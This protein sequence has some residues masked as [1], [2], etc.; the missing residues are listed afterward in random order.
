[1]AIDRL[2]AAEWNANSII[3][4]P[5]A[6]DAEFIRRAY[7]DVTGRIPP[8]SA[9]RDFLADESPDRRRDLID[10]LLGTATY[11][12]HSTNL[13]R[14]AMIPEA[15]AD[16]QI[17]FFLPGFEAWL[18]SRI[19][20]NRNYAQ[21]VEEV[22]TLPFDPS[23][24][25][26]FQQPDAPTPAAFYRAKDAQPENLAAATARIFLGLRLECAQCHDH[27][28]DKWKRDEFW[29]YAAF[30]TSLSGEQVM[31]APNSDD[32]STPA[33]QSSRGALAGA[34]A[35]P[36][37]M[38]P[39]TGRTVPARFLDGSEPNWTVDADSRQMLAKWVTSP[40]NEFFARAA[41]NRIWANHFGIG[42]VDPV[43]DLSERNPPSHPEVLDLLADE[44]A[45]HDFDVKFVIRVVT[46][47]RAYGLTSR[48]THESQQT[49]RMFARMA[50]KGLTP[51]QIFDSIAQATGYQ[52]PFNPEEPLNFNNDQRRQEFLENFANSS[53]APTERQSTIL[54]ALSLMNG[55]F[56]A[57]ATD[58]SESRTLA[59]VAESPFLDAQEKV[60]AL[61]LAALSR[62]PAAD[63]SER[64]TAYASAGS[65]TDDPDA[66]LGD[67]FWALLNSSEFLMN[68]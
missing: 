61:F 4:A 19:A 55:E 44:F 8:A 10:R 63:E 66:A 51:E 30:F 33:A 62:P 21:I 54:Q 52:Q 58:L 32:A 48:Q 53:D 50:V 49:P 47:T 57:A 43:D 17:R 67:V 60:E 39:G 42:L 22:L 20:E 5:E 7:L 56:V 46:T 36:V 29:S 26:Q 1:A 23:Q 64:F 13:W 59:A 65:S 31:R 27:F 40:E 35:A 14:A 38:I 16:Q 34:L 24:M 37:V 15:D 28:F 45:K 3:P 68:H 12:V 18:R 6:D 41:V 25:Q 2:I 11:I 9:V